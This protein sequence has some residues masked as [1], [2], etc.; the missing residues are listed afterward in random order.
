MAVPFAGPSEWN[1]LRS[2]ILSTPGVVGLDVSSLGGD[3]A[4]VKLTVMGDMDTIEETFPHQRTAAVQGGQVMGHPAT[5][6]V[7]AMPV[8]L[9]NLITIG[10]ILLVPVTVWLII[11]HQ[12]L[13][14]LLAFLAAGISDG[15]DGYIARRFNQRSELGAYLDPIADK[16]LL[17]S[18]YVSLAIL[19]VL[20]TWLAIIVVT[21]D[22]LIVG[23]VVL[24]WVMGRPLDMK[25]LWISKVNTVAQIVLRGAC[26][27]PSRP[28]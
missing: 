16:A 6:R 21:R 17:V 19:E 7:P 8:S 13:L 26:C 18:I 5:V 1:R 15:V 12:Y 4:V 27:W 20:P 11:N 25:P 23:A 28:A 3:G 2:R 10:R 24:A 14:A 22:V 9:P